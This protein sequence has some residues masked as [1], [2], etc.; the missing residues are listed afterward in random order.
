MAED[1]IHENIYPKVHQD[2]PHLKIVDEGHKYRL[3]RVRGYTSRSIVT[4]LMHY[5]RTHKRYKRAYN[6]LHNTSMT[7]GSLSLQC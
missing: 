5:Q 4:E 1:I 2:A 7:L 3:Q 6:F